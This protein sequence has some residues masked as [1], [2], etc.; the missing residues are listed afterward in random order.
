MDEELDWSEELCEAAGR[1]RLSY[2]K[3]LL[4]M[5]ADVDARDARNVTPLHYA[6]FYRHTAVV[7]VLC[8]YALS[9]IHI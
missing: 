3:D 6:V 1:G 8:F 5:G 2:V 9:L 4:D 7:D